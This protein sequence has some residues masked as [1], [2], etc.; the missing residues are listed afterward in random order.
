MAAP[1]LVT[2]SEGL[3]GSALCRALQ[4]FGRPVRRL[5]VRADDPASRG[6]VRDPGRV[7]DA[8]SGCSG[9]IALAAVSRVVWGE[10]APDACW[11]TNVDALASLVAAAA[12]APQ[13]PWLVFASSREVYGQP[14]LL[15][16]TED[17]PLHPVNVYGRSKAEGE[18]LVAASGLRHAILRLSNVYGS[19]RDHVDRVVPAFVRAALSNA[20]LRVDGTDNTF[21]FTHITD[22]VD[23]IARVVKRLE[24]GS[25]T[26]PPI[27]FVSGTSTTLGRLA[28]DVVRLA[29]SVS[30]ILVGPA[31]NFDVSRFVGDPSRAREL[32]DW[33]PMTPLHAGL[34]HL[35]EATRDQ[36]AIESRSAS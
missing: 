27:H 4:A 10:R 36:I 15:P 24:A 16:A 19:P 31:R 35:I 20:P 5:D 11:A 2:G 17:T 34:T 32:L 18:R 6:D 25:S 14:G 7:R 30:P 23:G 12:A 8:V 28:T 22:V 13:R 1:I 21:D 9:I 26:L 3:V 29:G 33:R